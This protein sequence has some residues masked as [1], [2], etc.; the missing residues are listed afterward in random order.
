MRIAN[1][2]GRAYLLTDEGTID[3][4]EFSG[5]RYGPDPMDLFTQWPAFHDW[6][7]TAPV[8][9]GV[10]YRPEDLGAPVPRPRQVFAIEHAGHFGDRLR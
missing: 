7:R 1:L 10:P 3:I 2:N 8:E 5:G 6:A 9:A 4:A